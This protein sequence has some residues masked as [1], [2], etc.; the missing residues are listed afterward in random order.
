VRLSCCERELHPSGALARRIYVS[1][2]A[3]VAVSE[4]RAG[5]PDWGAIYAREGPG[6]LR[7]ARRLSAS[8]DEARD[9]LQEVFVRAMRTSSRPTDASRFRPWL[10]R[11]VTNECIDRRRRRR[12]FIASLDAVRAPAPVIDTSGDALVRQALRSIPPDQAAALVLRLQEG[13]SR[14]EIASH[15][16]I[17][18]E[19]VKSRL[20]RGRLNFAAA[21]RRLERGLAR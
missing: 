14:A 10:Y 11:I 13:R 19:G 4:E 18:E 7:F 1:F 20:A 3:G 6:L 16:G 5:S 15:L 2:D 9:V 8:D 12:F 21:Y 17:S